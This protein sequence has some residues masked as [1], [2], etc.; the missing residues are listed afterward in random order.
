MKDAHG[1][2]NVD[3]SSASVLLVVT[4]V[5]L[6]MAL[7]FACCCYEAGCSPR[8]WRKKKSQARLTNEIS[9]LSRMMEETNKRIAQKNLTLEMEEG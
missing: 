5:A 8:S 7:L 9:E 6:G 3:L 4:L 2:I 1:L